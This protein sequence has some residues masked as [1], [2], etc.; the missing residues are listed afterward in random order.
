MRAWGLS[1][2][3]AEPRWESD[4]VSAI[5]VPE[6][7]DAREVIRV[8]YERYRASF[9]TGLAQVAG[10]VFR[11]GH[12]GDLNEGSCLTALAIAEMAL[13]DAGTRI[14]LGSGVAAAQGWYR[15]SNA[16]ETSRKAAA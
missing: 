10:R 14:E 13:R 15:E 3:A 16:T 12:L 9:G 2:C 11:I 5:V 6:G 1:L 4:T 8:G 7:V